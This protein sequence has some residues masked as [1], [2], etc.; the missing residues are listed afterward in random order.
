MLFPQFEVSTVFISWLPLAMSFFSSPSHSMAAPEW[1]AAIG[2]LILAVTAMI[3]IFRELKIFP[4]SDPPPPPPQS[5]PASSQEVQD[6]LREMREVKELLESRLPPP[7]SSTLP[8]P[9]GALSL[10]ERVKDL[11]EI[12]EDAS[13]ALNAISCANKSMF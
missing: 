6:L 13:V 7:P 3:T 2:T 9:S 10:E 4:K 8:P 1:I 11:E 12:A 5:Q